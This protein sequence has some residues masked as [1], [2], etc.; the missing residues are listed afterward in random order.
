MSH[1]DYHKLIYDHVPL[2][3]SYFVIIKEDVP[4]LSSQLTL[5]VQQMASQG[6][7]I[8]VE[9]GYG[10]SPACSCCESPNSTDVAGWFMSWK[11]PREELV[12]LGVPP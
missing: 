12:I 10:H 1:V 9:T 2:L 11:I 7:E 6:V 8:A 4:S 3:K 5:L